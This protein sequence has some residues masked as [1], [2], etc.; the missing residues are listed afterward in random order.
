[1]PPPPPP[2]PPSPIPSG[3]SVRSDGI[4]I[5]RAAARGPLRFC[6]S[7]RGGPR[8]YRADSFNHLTIV[9][10]GQAYPGLRHPTLAPRTNRSHGTA[11]SKQSSPAAVPRVDFMTSQEIER[12]T[13][14]CRRLQDGSRRIPFPRSQSASSV[15]RNSLLAFRIRFCLP[16]FVDSR[17]PRS[18]G[19]LQGAYIWEGGGGK[20]S[21]STRVYDLTCL[22]ALCCRR[23]SYLLLS[24]P[25]GDIRFFHGC[26]AQ[27]LRDSPT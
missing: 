26:V 5:T 20:F 25:F 3:D 24:K 10:L 8:C 13:F 6:N 11:R 1:M 2:P 22:I 21:D 23:V 18:T 14:H 27:R 19:T 16:S 17:L 15:S 9:L 12:C 7:D 4:K